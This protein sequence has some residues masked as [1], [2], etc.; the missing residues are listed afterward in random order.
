MNS[1]P[2]LRTP[3]LIG[4][5][6]ERERPFRNMGEREEKISGPREMEDFTIWVEYSKYKPQLDN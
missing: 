5:E 4:R 3:G 2:K 1:R 6:R